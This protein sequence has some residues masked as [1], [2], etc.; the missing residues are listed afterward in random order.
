MSKT[1]KDS[2]FIRQ[3]TISLEDLLSVLPRGARNV[4]VAMCLGI[5]PN[6]DDGLQV[7]WEIK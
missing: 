6:S 2:F 3:T 1:K 4:Q 5:K 7:S